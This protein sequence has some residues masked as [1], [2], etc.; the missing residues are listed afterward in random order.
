MLIGLQA[1]QQSKTNG[2]P[3]EVAQLVLVDCPQNNSQLLFGIVEGAEQGSFF[4]RQAGTEQFHRLL[5]SVQL[6]KLGH[7]RLAVGPIQ[8]ETP[9]LVWHCVA[10]VSDVGLYVGQMMTAAAERIVRSVQAPIEQIIWSQ[11]NVD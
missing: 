11:G 7:Q 2:L 4:R 9:L 3:F 10:S 5:D 8:G 6:L 1:F